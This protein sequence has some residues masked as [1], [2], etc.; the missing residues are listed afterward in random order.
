[1]DSIKGTDRAHDMKPQQDSKHRRSEEAK[2]QRGA[3]R[4]GQM[5]KQRADRRSKETAAQRLGDTERSPESWEAK[6]ERRN[7]KVTTVKENLYPKQLEKQ[8]SH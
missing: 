8:R 1:M 5:P 7:I 4:K 3:R 6:G 2:A